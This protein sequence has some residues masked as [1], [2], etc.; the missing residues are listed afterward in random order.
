[1]NL[2]TNS[3][4]DE[5]IEAAKHLVDRENMLEHCDGYVLTNQRELDKAS[6]ELHDLRQ[7]FLEKYRP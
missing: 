3:D 4:L 2:K 7:V 1:M 5:L 6:K